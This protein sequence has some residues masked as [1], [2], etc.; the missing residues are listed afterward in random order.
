MSAIRVLIADDAKVIRKT[1]R[2]FLESES[3][4][5]VCGEAA[6]FSQTIELAANLR[7]DVILLDLHMLDS[8][9][10]APSVVKAKL[11][12]TSHVLAMSLPM[13]ED[14]ID[15]L[16]SEYGAVALLDKA[17]LV[18]ELIPAIQSLPRNVPPSK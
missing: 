13:E 15:T 5:Q 11:L 7:P 12:S 6:S 14:H 10:F 16:A 8:D 17:K 1:V 9:D 18:D 4:V 2:N 3:T